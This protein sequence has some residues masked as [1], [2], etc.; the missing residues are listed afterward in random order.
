[1]LWQTGCS[2]CEEFMPKLNKIVSKYGIEVYNLNLANLS[3]DER[4]K[5][6]NKLHIKYTPTTVYIEDGAHRNTE[7]VRI[8]GDKS[9]E[10]IIKFLLDNNYL[11]EK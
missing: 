3:E 9:E 8:V 11:K 6:N 1:M 7:Q 2:H 5:L 10:D 4:T